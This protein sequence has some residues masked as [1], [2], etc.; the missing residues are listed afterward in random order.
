[1]LALHYLTALVHAIFL[2]RSQAPEEGNDDVCLDGVL[3]IPLCFV[4]ADSIAENGLHADLGLH[5]D[6]VELKEC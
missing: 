5:A 3:I 1:M 2:K 6:P 4:S